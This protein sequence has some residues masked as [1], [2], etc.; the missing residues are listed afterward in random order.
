ML[1]ILVSNDVMVLS[2]SE[3][4]E[5]KKFRNDILAGLDDYDGD[6]KQV[7]VDHIMNKL[8]EMHDNIEKDRHV[9][10]T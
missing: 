5:C 7:V 3:V 2:G 6:K 8:D 4:M 10:R 1:V 9:P